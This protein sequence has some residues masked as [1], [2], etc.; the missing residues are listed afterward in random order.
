MYENIKDI[1][2]LFSLDSEKLFRLSDETR[3]KYAGEGVYLRGIIEFSNICDKH[4]AYCGISADNSGLERYHLSAE[5]VLKAVDHIT[6]C[7]I[8]TVVLQSGETDSLDTDWLGLIVKEI[9]SSYDMAVTLSVGE[10]SFSIYKKWKDAGADRYLLKIETT[11]PEIY[12][13]LHPGMRL[14]NRKRSLLD[15]KELGFQTGSGTL[16]G[17]PG[18][19]LHD[20]ASDI[21]YFNDSGFEMIGTG[22]FIPHKNTPLHGAKAGDVDLVLRTIAVTRIVMK[23]VNMPATTAIGSLDQDYRDEALKWGANVLMPNF[24]PLPYKKLYEI[25]PGKRCILE[26]AGACA[27]CME[28]MAV[29]SGRFIDWGRGD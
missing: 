13:K 27:G 20:I 16:I 18:Q 5:E 9:K 10:K 14:E 15:L 24:T 29:G 28:N 3:R 25:Y 12:A 6:S 21:K 7:G 17:L 4:C 8:K 22:P 19:T 26:P 11:N 2:N 1:E 23:T